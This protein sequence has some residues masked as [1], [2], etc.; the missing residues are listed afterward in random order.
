[1]I[2]K[3]KVRP[4]LFSKLVRVGNRFDGGY[5][6]PERALN[7]CNFLLSLGINDDI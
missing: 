3:N 5:V 4:F 2:E 1:M 7:S 6:L